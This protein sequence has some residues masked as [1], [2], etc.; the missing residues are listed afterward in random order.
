MEEQLKD[1]Q[2]NVLVEGGGENKQARADTR[3]RACVHVFM[4]SRLTQR[5]CFSG[6]HQSTNASAPPDMRVLCDCLIP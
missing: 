2:V 5:D 4:P 1:L 3:G 6:W